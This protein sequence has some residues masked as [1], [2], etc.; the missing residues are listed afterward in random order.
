MDQGKS[1]DSVGTSSTSNNTSK[2]K[3]YVFYRKPSLKKKGPEV[4]QTRT[5]MKRLLIAN[6]LL[7]YEKE[8][9]ELAQLEKVIANGLETAPLEKS[10]QK[11]ATSNK[12][13]KFK[14]PK[15]PP[16]HPRQRINSILAGNSCDNGSSGINRLSTSKQSIVDFSVSTQKILSSTLRE[17][18]PP[19]VQ[20]KR[21]AKVEQDK[22]RDAKIKET[23]PFR[24]SI[25]AQHFSRKNSMLKADQ[26]KRLV[27]PKFTRST[28]SLNN[29]IDVQSDT[30]RHEISAIAE[31]SRESSFVFK[32]PNAHERRSRISTPLSTA[33]S[34]R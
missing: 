34:R 23:K 13:N 6:P 7:K 29:F 26:E 19:L 5:S 15:V 3:K 24:R 8:G 12:E 17:G 2:E 33:S 25:S 10:L 11:S 1:S 21:L 18:K 14:D 22:K 27:K 9:I 4:K 31:G 16:V 28:D 30:P 32:T 20:N